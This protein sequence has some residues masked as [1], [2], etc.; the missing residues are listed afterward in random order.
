MDGVV[1]LKVI[2]GDIARVGLFFWEVVAAA[3]EFDGFTIDLVICRVGVT[4]VQETVNS[5]KK[6][7]KRIRF[8]VI[9]SSQQAN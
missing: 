1:I 5:I 7:N 8:N 9:V 4:D 6:R 3:I 2:V